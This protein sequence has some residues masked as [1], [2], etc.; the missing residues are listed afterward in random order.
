MNSM[1]LVIPLHSLYWSIH[2]KDEM[3]DKFHGIRVL[4]HSGGKGEM[5]LLSNVF[6]HF[7]FYSFIFRLNVP[8]AIEKSEAKSLLR[9]KRAWFWSKSGAEKNRESNERNREA[10]ERNRESNLNR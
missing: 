4:P 3:N 10:G 9:V 7:D 2:T 8:R 1:K 5:R 6:L